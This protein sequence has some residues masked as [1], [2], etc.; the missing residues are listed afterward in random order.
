[1]RSFLAH[2][3][4]FIV[5]G[6]VAPFIFAYYMLF[7]VQYCLYQ[8]WRGYRA[9]RYWIRYGSRARRAFLRATALDY[10][11]FTTLRRDG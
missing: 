5:A 7:Y 10:I 4:A 11:T 1:M 8:L 3:I 9:L 2:L 6:I